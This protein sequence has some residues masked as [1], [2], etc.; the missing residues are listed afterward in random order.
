[1]NTPLSVLESPILVLL[2]NKTEKDGHPAALKWQRLEDVLLQ[3]K[4]LALQPHRICEN[5]WLLPAETSRQLV[6]EFLMEA[7]YLKLDY[8]AYKIEGTVAEQVV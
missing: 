7:G 1:M 4:F 8:I 5:V 3:N 2:K 6:R